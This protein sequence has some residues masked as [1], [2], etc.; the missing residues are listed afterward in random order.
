MTT[1]WQGWSPS[2][3][4][5]CEG[6]LSAGESSMLSWKRISP[7]FMVFFVPS[8][9]L[10]NLRAD[11]HQPCLLSL[12]CRSGCCQHFLFGSHICTLAIVRHMCGCCHSEGHLGKFRASR[13]AQSIC[14]LMNNDVEVPFRP[15]KWPHSCCIH[16]CLYASACL[17]SCTRLSKTRLAGTVMFEV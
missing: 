9:V 6:G 5:K 8:V 12:T 16:I 15:S 10:T 1:C 17:P 7:A 14:E 13:Q 4:E 2:T 3:P 11:N